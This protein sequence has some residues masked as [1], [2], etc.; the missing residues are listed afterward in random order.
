MTIAFAVSFFDFRND[1]RRVIAEVQRHH[2]VVLLTN[3]GQLADIERHA[4]AGCAVR[5]IEE[6]APGPAN[7]LTRLR[8]RLRR[9]IP[10][11]EQNFYLMES[12]KAGRLTGNARRLAEW[13]TRLHRL[14]PASY[15]YDE[16]L[17]DLTYAGNTK[18]DD[19]D[20]FVCFTEIADDYLM[21][22]LVRER[23]PLVTYVYSWDHACKHTR[24]SRRSVNLVW[25]EDIG[26]DLVELQHI[27]REQIAVIGASQFCYIHEYRSRRQEFQDRIF[28]FPY[29]YF[30][31][32]IGI[33]SLV[34]EEVE[35]ALSLADALRDTRPDLK[36][37][38]RPYPPLRNW[39][40]YDR[41]YAH[42]TI[43]MDDD[44]RQTDRA[45]R[46]EDLMSKF[47]KLDQAAAFFHLGTTLGLECCFLDTPSFILDVNPDNGQPVSTYH[48][49]H[50]YQNEKY[51]MERAPLNHC[52]SWDQ[53]RTILGE[54]ETGRYRELNHLVQ[55]GEPLQS[56]SDFATRL[57]AL[58]ASRN[59]S[60][61]TA[62]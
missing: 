54:V 19:I 21:A 29:V 24:F 50:Q 62:Q 55:T 8:Y 18:L 37:V 42:P 58:A 44:F 25:N 33:E 36:L 9:A 39:S 52:R 1:V 45:V 60:P 11:S 7:R 14:L 2:H 3:R 12:F 22:R 48:F 61:S 4:P 59:A 41:L 16:Y 43:V 13:T 31:C 5:L 47:V 49:T 34:P 26:Q 15:G 40:L 27:P 6:R 51:L 38:V 20:A 10:A 30:G 46:Q 28:D 32:A 17:D 35:V 56:F 53:L 57:T 23:R